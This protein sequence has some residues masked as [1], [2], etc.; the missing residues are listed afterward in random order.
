MV[1]LLTVLPSPSHHDRPP[2]GRR[3]VLHGNSLRASRHTA[4]PRWRPGCGGAW[5]QSSD[6]IDHDRS[7]GGDRLLECRGDLAR[8]LD[9]DTAH[10]EAAGD[11]AKIGRPE[12]D[13]GLAAV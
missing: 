8:L 3:P 1:T 10:T 4:L 12:A 11:L 7:V 6:D 13:Q 2:P 9:T 5:L